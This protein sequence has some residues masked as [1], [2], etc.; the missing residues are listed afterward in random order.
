MAK[1]SAIQ[2][3]FNAG[4]L[5][6]TLD[7]RVDLAKYANGC[8]AM[9]NFYPLVQGGARKRSGTRHVA[10]VKTSSSL[11]RLIPFEFGTTQLQFLSTLYYDQW[12]AFKWLFARCE[13]WVSGPVDSNSRQGQLLRV[14]K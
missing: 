4:E 13:A 7:G 1:A 2:T 9:E 8:A 14:L 10:E 6:P 3:S 5:S 11:T 12:P